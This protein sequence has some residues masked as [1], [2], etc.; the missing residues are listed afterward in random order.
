MVRGSPS[1]AFAAGS[2]T[3][4]TASAA[5]IAATNNPP[6]VG[7]QFTTT[8]SYGGLGESSATASRRSTPTKLSTL[9]AA[10]S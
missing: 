5:N 10:R 2:L 7:P 1:S 3:S 6:S 9:R 4:S 8:R